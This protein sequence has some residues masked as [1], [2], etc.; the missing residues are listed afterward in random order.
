VPLS[1][2]IRAAVRDADL[3]VFGP[4]SLFTSVIPNLLLEGLM[5]EINANSSPRVYISNIMTQP[6]ETIGFKLS[7]HIRALRRH[8]G[9][10]FPDQ[11]L[12]HEGD[13]PQVVVQ[14]YQAEGAEPVVADVAGKAEFRGLRVIQRDFFAGGETARHDPARLARILH[15]EFLRS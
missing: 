3:F 1:A 6:G 12:A 7:D 11:V 10:D 13:L 14:K 8:V 15:E 5:E 9:D 4:G 2:E